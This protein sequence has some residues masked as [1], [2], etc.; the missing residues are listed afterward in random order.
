MSTVVPKQDQRIIIY[1]SNA[2]V[3]TGGS[4][5]VMGLGNVAVM[6]CYFWRPVYL[7]CS[8]SATHLHPDGLDAPTQQALASDRL[9]L[10]KI[11]VTIK[12]FRFLIPEYD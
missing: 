9:S 7:T 6:D 10:C 8:L 4:Q 12:I 11:F 5:G 2:R 3:G 1:A